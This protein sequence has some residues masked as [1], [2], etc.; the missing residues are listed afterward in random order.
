MVNQTVCLSSRYAKD[1]KIG[2]DEKGILA[3]STLLVVDSTTL[4]QKEVPRLKVVKTC[5]C[6]MKP[7]GNQAGFSV[8]ITVKKLA[9]GCDISLT[10]HSERLS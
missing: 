6:G 4:T 10:F 1:V 3:I 8:Y 5:I 7:N 2:S 9:L